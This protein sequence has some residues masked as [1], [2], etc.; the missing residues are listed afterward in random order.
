MFLK[1][2]LFISFHARIAVGLVRR[3]CATVSVCLYNMPVD[4][5]QESSTSET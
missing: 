4:R 5:L 3:I 1:F 2:T